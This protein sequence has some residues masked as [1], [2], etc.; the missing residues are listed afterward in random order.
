MK[1][2]FESKH[3]IVFLGVLAILAFVS[4]MPNVAAQTYT[5][6]DNPTGPLQ[7]MAWSAGIAVAAVLSGVGIYTTALK[8]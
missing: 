6:A 2:F 8:H 4:V 7:A 5:D 1:T 3:A